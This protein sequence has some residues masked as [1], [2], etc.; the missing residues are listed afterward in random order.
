MQ[1]QGYYK[2]GYL[3]LTRILK[4]IFNNFHHQL[5]KVNCKKSNIISNKK[6]LITIISLTYI[7]YI[8]NYAYIFILFI[9]YID[10]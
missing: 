10:T 3:Q 7:Y 8:I 4:E 2:Y 6:I 1:T 5:T 9:K